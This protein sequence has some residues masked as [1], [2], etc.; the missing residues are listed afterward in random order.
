MCHNYRECIVFMAQSLSHYLK[1]AK[2]NLNIT[3][4]LEY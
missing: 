2:K 4:Y 1:Y 3:I